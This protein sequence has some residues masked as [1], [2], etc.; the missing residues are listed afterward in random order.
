MRYMNFK[1]RWMGWTACLLGGA[2]LFGGCA[3]RAPKGAETADPTWNGV[4]DST[5]RLGVYLATTPGSYS[6][7]GFEIMSQAEET[8]KQMRPGVRWT[9]IDSSHP[10]TYKLSGW[11]LDSLGWS[12]CN[13]SSLKERKGSGL[14]K[15]S[16][17]LASQTRSALSRVQRAY[18]Q[19][20]LVV[21]RAGGNRA[22]KDSSKTFQDQAWIGLFDLS[23]G[24][25]LYSLEAPSEGKQSAAASAECDWAKTVW[26]EFRQALENL[27]Q[28]LR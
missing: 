10:G 5:V 13:D 22:E 1:F 21:V 18:A 17:S 3:A 14:K 27:P 24:K 11:D 16:T 19:D 2:L 28:R 9:W 15:A 20:Y 8:M 12:I 4:I 6:Q 26:G 23:K 25:L 7:A